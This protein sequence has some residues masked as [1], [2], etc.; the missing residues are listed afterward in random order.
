MTGT[1]PHRREMGKLGAE[2]KF[3]RDSDALPCL[4]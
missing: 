4:H 3:L 1:L 2:L